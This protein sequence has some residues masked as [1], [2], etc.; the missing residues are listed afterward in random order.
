M[1]ESDWLMNVLKCAIVFREAVGKK[2]VD[3]SSR[4]R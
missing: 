4:G 1:L 2:S 3:Q